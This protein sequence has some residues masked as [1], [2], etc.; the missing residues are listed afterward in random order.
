MDICN[1]PN[2]YEASYSKN[3]FYTG[4]MQFSIFLRNSLTPPLPPT[5]LLSPNN[6]TPPTKIKISDPPQQMLFQNF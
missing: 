1:A 2:V 6:T 5:K 3:T 4:F